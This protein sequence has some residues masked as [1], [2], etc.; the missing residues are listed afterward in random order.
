MLTS[1]GTAYSLL[2]TLPRVISVGLPLV[3]VESAALAYAHR[4]WKRRRIIGP[5]G[6]AAPPRAKL[7]GVDLS[8]LALVVLAPAAQAGVGIPGPWRCAAN[9]GI[10]ALYCYLVANDVCCKYSDLVA[11]QAALV[12]RGPHTVSTLA[13]ISAQRG[14]PL[15]AVTLGGTN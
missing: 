6:G 9:G 11:G 7:K 8:L 14:V 12:G 10:N 3:L 15:R 5:R 2:Q 1:K 4:R 13:Q